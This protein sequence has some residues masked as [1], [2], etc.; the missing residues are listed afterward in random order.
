MPVAARVHTRPHAP[1][2]PPA[3]SGHRRRG[4]APAVPQTLGPGALSQPR[5]ENKQRSPLAAHTTPDTHPH[6]Q[7]ALGALGTEVPPS[8]APRH[9]LPGTKG[10]G[11]RERRGGPSYCRGGA[12]VGREPPG[13]GPSGQLLRSPRPV[14]RGGGFPVRVQSPAG[15]GPAR[16]GQGCAPCP[17]GSRH[18]PP[19]PPAPTPHRR[20]PPLQGLFL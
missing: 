18:P 14:R 13:A 15:K 10:G 20:R 17:K 9:P 1:H 8:A 19:A 6:R 3:G 4:E 16:G 5:T 12:H 2:S 11:S 7:Q